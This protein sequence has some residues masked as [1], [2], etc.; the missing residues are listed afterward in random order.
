M[1]PQP[2]LEPDML[3]PDR[4]NFVAI[5]G[6][7]GSGKSVRA[8]D[9][10]EHW[11]G[12]AMVI[13]VIGDVAPIGPDGRPVAKTTEPPERWPT[14]EV[15]GRTELV[16][17]VWF[18]P[19]TMDPA[20][21]E[22]VDVAIGLCHRTP[23]SLLWLDEVHL[24][25]PVHTTKASMPAARNA[26]ITGRHTPM[27]ILACGPRPRDIDRLVLQQADHVI[28]YHLP[29]VEDRETIAGNVGWDRHDFHGRHA[30]LGRHE[31]LWVNVAEHRMTHYDPVEIRRPRPT[32]RS[33]S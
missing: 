16:P 20:W 11:P 8:R 13:D 30:E 17:R 15:H 26:L 12:P 4:A 2:E 19:S 28:V 22:K 31:Y 25:L 14:H 7:K 29:S 32:L 27:S 5:F 1:S 3:D 9:F 33:R 24:L 10:F 6:R 23:Y 21:L 18:V